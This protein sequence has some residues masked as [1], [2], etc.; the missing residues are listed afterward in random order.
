MKRRRYDATDPVREGRNA[1]HKNPESWKS[2]RRLE[3]TTENR[4][5]QRKQYDDTGCRLCI[6][7][8]GNSHMRKG[9]GVDKELDDKEKDQ[10]L[11]GRAL[12]AHN[13][14]VE[15]GVN[16]NRS[17]DLIGNFHDDISNDEC[18]P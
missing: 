13:W 3:Y 8:S 10:P 6:R 14:V 15:A 12:D 18:L 9:T 17:N 4:A 5:H 16:E 1:V 7:H 2:S 11:L